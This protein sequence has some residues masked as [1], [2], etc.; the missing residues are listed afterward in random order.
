MITQVLTAGD[1]WFYIYVIIGRASQRR[2]KCQR[3]EIA[4]FHRS[5]DETF[6]EKGFLAPGQ[7][8][9]SKWESGRGRQTETEDRKENS[10]VLVTA[11]EIEV[12]LKRPM[13]T[14]WFSWNPGSSLEHSNLV[15]SL[16]SSKCCGFILWNKKSFEVSLNCKVVSNSLNENWIP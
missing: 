7:N 10:L 14:V 5:S 8:F 16:S 9:W 6:I 11:T 13:P 3:T 4:T 12:P 2:Q 15:S 1:T